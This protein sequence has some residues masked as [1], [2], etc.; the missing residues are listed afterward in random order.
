MKIK[1]IPTQTP[2]NARRITSTMN[3]PSREPRA[4][5]SSLREVTPNVTLTASFASD[6]TV[7]SQLSRCAKECQLFTP[8][9][10]LSAKVFVVH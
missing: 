7:V 1:K 9:C 10:L 4:S 5:N 2:Q 8:N 6:E 3:S